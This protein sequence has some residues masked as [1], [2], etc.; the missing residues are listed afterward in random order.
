MG[1]SPTQPNNQR[2]VNYSGKSAAPTGAAASIP[3]GK[4][5][6]K[7]NLILNAKQHAENDAAM[8]VE[9]SGKDQ[10]GNGRNFSKGEFNGT[11]IKSAINALKDL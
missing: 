2:L 8:E 3:T 5:D 10:T 7:G 1:G 9:N 6:S 11:S 4:V